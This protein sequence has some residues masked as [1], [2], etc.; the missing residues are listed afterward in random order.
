MKRE[1][2]DNNSNT[3]NSNIIFN[4]RRKLLPQTPTVG[5]QFPRI[6]PIRECDW[7]KASMSTNGHAAIELFL[8][9]TVSCQKFGPL[10]TQVL[11]KKPAP[12]TFK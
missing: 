5:T 10:Q 3:N 1:R 2:D 8:D 4:K 12:A 11:G 7:P 6:F 9:Q